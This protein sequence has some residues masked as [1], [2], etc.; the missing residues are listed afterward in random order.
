MT[1]TAPLP[2]VSAEDE[3]GEIL[4]E[5]LQFPALESQN[6]EAKPSLSEDF[7]LPAL[8]EFT[9]GT[10]AD[11]SFTESGPVGLE[12]LRDELSP[13]VSR[14]EELSA[15]PS[16]EI[17]TSGEFADAS[18]SATLVELPNNLARP[19]VTD[20]LM[21]AVRAIPQTMG[22]KI[23]DAADLV[24]VKQY[25]LRYWETEFSELRPKKSRNGQR[26]YSRRDVESALL[27]KK[28]L[29][30]DRFSIEGARAAL[31]ALR[32]QV[33]EEKDWNRQLDQLEEAKTS[34]AQEIR[35]LNE[36]LKA[37]R[38]RIARVFAAKG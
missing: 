36:R 32:S 22:F 30:E 3:I 37:L 31:K 38:Q 4:E 29:Y 24:G 16:T 25:V 15:A 20:Q 28:L 12:S 6:I 8:A 9:L 19:Q 13:I 35:R 7:G 11:Y 18:G 23:G 10:E 27:I 21:A 33:R 5:Q 26:I 17:Q 14:L 1:E 2:K 34:A